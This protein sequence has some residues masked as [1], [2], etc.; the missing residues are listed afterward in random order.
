MN[1]TAAT[2]RRVLMA[3]FLYYRHDLSVMSDDDFDRACRFLAR[4]WR[5]L[6][7]HLRWQLESPEAI[8]ATGYHC[9]ITMQCEGGATMWASR[10]GLGRIKRVPMS[11]W[12]RQFDEKRQVHW[13]YAGG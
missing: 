2:A 7:D 9:R 12:V 8:A 5:A 6:D 11:E 1:L 10:V 4:R 3:S 13:V